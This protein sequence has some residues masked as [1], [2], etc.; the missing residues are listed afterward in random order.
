MINSIIIICTM[1]LL[2][3]FFSG[4]EIAFLSKNRLREEIDRKQ[5]PLFDFIA[6][7]FERHS[8]QYI[9]TIL[10]GNNIALVIYS[11]CLSLV[12]REIARMLGWTSVQE[13][14]ILL[15]TIIPTIVIIFLGE[16]LPKSIF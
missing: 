11:M 14:S 5:S 4:M 1:L 9:T 12:L 6:Q 16:Y 3:A 10:V 15:E 7:L 8:G 2:S 13:G